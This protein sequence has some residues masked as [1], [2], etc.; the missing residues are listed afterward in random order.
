VWFRSKFEIGMNH[1]MRCYGFDGH[2]LLSENEEELAA[3][4]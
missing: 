2:G 4:L 1:L 3:A